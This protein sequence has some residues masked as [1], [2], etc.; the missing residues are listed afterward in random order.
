MNCFGIIVKIYIFFFNFHKEVGGSKIIF[1]TSFKVPTYLSDTRWD[2]R[3]K[4]TEAILESY[5]AITNALSHLHSDV[6]EKGD[7]RLRANN[8]LQKEKLEVVFMLHF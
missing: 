2:A 5:C 8:F 1:A 4:A 6:G 7:T 3:A